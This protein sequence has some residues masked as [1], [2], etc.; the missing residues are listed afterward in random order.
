MS[1]LLAVLLLSVSLTLLPAVAA[2]ASAQ[3]K[4]AKTSKSRAKAKHVK[5][6]AGKKGQRE[7]SVKFG[8]D[9]VEGGRQVPVGDQIVG[10]VPVTHASLIR[11]RTSFLREMLLSAENL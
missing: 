4:K 1:R 9:E 5:K 6:V 2:T 7:K 11:V 3:P 10:H 8:V